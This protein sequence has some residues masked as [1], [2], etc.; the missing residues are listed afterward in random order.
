MEIQWLKSNIHEVC[1]FIG[2]DISQ[3]LISGQ[4]FVPTKTGNVPVPVGS[5]IRKN[6]DGT[7][8]VS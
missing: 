4:L 8:T 6:K 1:S 5:Y 3:L 7:F 2:K